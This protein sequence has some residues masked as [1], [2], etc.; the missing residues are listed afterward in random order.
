MWSI[1]AGFIAMMF[2]C[3]PPIDGPVERARA[4]D[5][6][7]GDRLAVEL[8]ALPGAIA[9]DVVLHRPARDPFTGSAGPATAGVVVTVDDRADRVAIA[10]AATRL[11]HAA[12]PELDHPDVVV[13]VGA[14]RAELASVGPFT[15]EAHTKPRLA[16]AL[17][18][19]LAMIAALAGYIAWTARPRRSY[20]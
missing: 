15:V 10:N 9:A 14:Q 16:A 12:A 18:A 19:G 7:D 2:A 17:V 4:A 6:S 11:V 1:G 20:G 13:T 3:A 5:R 8:R